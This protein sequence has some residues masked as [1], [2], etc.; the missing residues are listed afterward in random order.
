[1][2][3]MDCNADIKVHLSKTERDEVPCETPSDIFRLPGLKDVN[4]ADKEVIDDLIFTSLQH[5]TVVPLLRTLWKDEGSKDMEI[6]TADRSVIKCHRS[7]FKMVSKFVSDLLIGT[8]QEEVSLHL[9]DFSSSSVESFL[10]ALYCVHRLHSVDIEI[11]RLAESLRIKF[12]STLDS[13]EEVVKKQIQRL[14]KSLTVKFST[15]LVAQEDQENMSGCQRLIRNVMAFNDF[16]LMPQAEYST[17]LDD[18]VKVEFND[19]KTIESKLESHQDVCDIVVNG[20]ELDY[21]DKK[22]REA[23]T[24]DRPYQCPMCNKKFRH[25]IG[26]RGH[27]RRVHGN[28]KLSLEE[29]EQVKKEMMGLNTYNCS[30]CDKTFTK[31]SKLRV[32]E[33]NCN[34]KH[35]CTTC[36]KSFASKYYLKDHELSHINGKL[37]SCTR[38]ESK[39]TTKYYLNFHEKAQH[40]G[41]RSFLCTQCDKMFVLLSDL[42][43]HELVHSGV[44]PFECKVCK[45]T[46]VFK[47]KLKRHELTH[48]GEKPFSCPRQGCDRRFTQLSH[49]KKH[50]LCH[51]GEKPFGCKT[52]GKAFTQKQHLN[53]HMKIHSVQRSA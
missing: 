50:E 22:S 43:K 7:I 17:S 13:K 27:E 3:G 31:K 28:F 4:H 20:N 46:F 35:V 1:M 45:K 34:T 44:R 24:S 49:V 38:C 8:G 18:E 6:L 42:K 48:S 16:N 52:C 26:L 14:A 41:E 12:C 37:F 15:P 11:Q 9:P 2:Y 40:D 36:G 21:E 10:K 5:A 23:K 32:H 39:F 29:R 30:T 47:H 51:T 53:R 33:K 19:K 25:T